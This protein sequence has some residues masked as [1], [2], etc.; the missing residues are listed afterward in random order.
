MYLRISLFLLF[1]CYSGVA[2]SQKLTKLEGISI[3]EADFYIFDITDQRKKAFPSVDAYRHQEKFYIAL[4][5]LFEGLRVKYS[6]IGNILS[7]D[8]GGKSTD[9]LLDQQSNSQGQW[10]HDGVFYFIQADVLEQLFTTK[11]TIDTNSLKLDLSGHLADFPYKTL[12]KQKKQRRINNYILAEQDQ[13]NNTH[14]GVITVPDQYRLATVPTGYLN[15]EYQADNFKKDF[16][17]VLQTV[18]DLAYHSTSITVTHNPYKT[19]S[20]VEF[21]RYPQYP[22]DKMLGIW[23]KYSFG[24]VWVNKSNLLAGSSRGLGL[25]LSTNNISNQHENMTTSFV[26]TAKP[27][28]EA[29]IYHNSVFLE[30]RVVPGDGL[31]EFNDMHLQYGANE[32]KIVLYGPYGEQEIIFERVNVRQNSLAQG[33][34]AF[35]MSLVEQDSSLLDIDLSEFDIDDISADFNIGLLDNWQVGATIN[36]QDIH[37]TNKANKSFLLKNQVT[38][39]GWFFENQMA[40]REGRFEQNSTL[41]TSFSNLDNFTLQYKSSTQ[42][43]IGDEDLKSSY[44]L[45]DYNIRTGSLINTLR[46]EKNDI[47]FGSIKTATHRISTMMPYFNVSNTITYRDNEN[48]GDN[49]SGSLTLTARIN[50]NFRFTSS[51]PYN[52][53]ADK[54]LNKESILASL[55]YNYQDDWDNR[56][57]LKVSN[58][59]FFKDNRW[60]V[61]YNLLLIAPTH[62]LTLRTNYNSQDKWRVTAGI[63]VN[64]GYDHFNHKMVFSNRSTRY[65]GTLDVHTYLDRRLNG[66][67]DVLDYDLPDVTFMGKNEWES[68]KS[69]SD[70]RARLFGANTGISALNAKWSTGGTTLNN[71]YLI[72]SH[73]GSVQKINLPF[74]LTTELEFFVVLNNEGQTLSLSNVPLIAINISTGDEYTTETD[75]DG[76]TSLVD[77]LPGK[78]RVYVDKKY[79]LDKGLQ[80]EIGGFEFDSPLRGG[81]VVL[82]NIELSRSESGAIGAN[83]LVKVLLDENNYA[84]LLDSDND[85]LIHLPPK[86]GMKAPYS[87]DALHLAKF[88]EIKMQSTEQ[89][90]R[91]LRNKLAEAT[92]SSRFFNARLKS[93]NELEQQSDSQ[94]PAVLVSP[95]APVSFISVP[96]EQVNTTDNLNTQGIIVD[97]AEFIQDLSSGYVVQFGAF[98]TLASAT[99]LTQSFSTIKQLHIIR[100]AVNGESIY[101]V[102][103]QVFQN[104][105]LAREYLNAAKTDGFIVDATKYID[106]VWSK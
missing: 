64:F 44:I 54:K 60:T 22:G 70:G 66:T 62:Q 35:A 14:A 78:Y 40:F 100:K 15:L 82:P 98:K 45:A 101:C 95:A 65:S 47:G 29:D 80:A 105:Q 41:A 55:T 25:K 49:L 104:E 53:R 72:Y 6:L 96:D 8:F 71:D 83:K 79:L 27:G 81:F 87:S 30:S 58:T 97:E 43:I 85:K 77:L 1:L 38:L 39:P 93:S 17:G 3:E 94:A 68:V 28:W 52:L 37:G 92:E 12:K 46:Y 21:T 31:M 51:I 26:K 76:Y 91:E 99:I 90:R 84:P 73:P 23:D 11:I 4:T 13:E 102:T 19:D 36:V 2:F 89:E 18:S 32:F 5:P 67:P 50:Q 9:L 56:H 103:S 106:I 74:Y 34:T 20:R 63:S 33:D 61:G 42:E 10:F 57:A 69:N 75:Y 48:L 88:R 24:D 7:V 59:S 86:G 16:S